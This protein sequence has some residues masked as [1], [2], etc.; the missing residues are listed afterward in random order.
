[1]TTIS[2]IDGDAERER[3]TASAALWD[4]WADPMAELADKLNQPL[5]DAAGVEPGSIVLD[6]ASG[7]GEPALSAARRA[8]PDGFVVGTDLVPAMLTGAMRR[9]AIVRSPP[10]FAAADMTALPFPDAAFDT[11]TCR[12]G[13][14][15]VPDAV[16]ALAEV[17]RVLKPGGR[18]AL[19]V[20]G[21]HT[22]NALFAV[23]GSVVEDR[24]GP[25]A[26]HALSPL[27]RYADA[28]SLAAAL[29]QAGFAQATETAR[30]P[31]RK[32]PRTQPFWRPTLDMVFGPLVA[33]LAPH[34][35]AALEA[36]IVRR[37]DALAQGDTVPLPAHVRIAVGV[38]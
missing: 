25:D 7:I 4:R 27:F 35:R 9:A 30:T 22:D 17:R 36:D 18:A 24:L 28:G 5:L 32:A 15:F 21:P 8:G 16:G 11:V 31:I 29:R 12:F 38:A 26:A 20:W 37:F 33:G 3:W 2:D 34:D 10:A 14:M 19:M 23:I 1:M 13:I 6:L